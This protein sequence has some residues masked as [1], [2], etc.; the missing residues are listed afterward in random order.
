M[1]AI[2]SVGWEKYVKAKHFNRYS[3]NE[4]KEEGKLSTPSIQPDS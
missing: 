1:N 3:Q 2:R 4:E